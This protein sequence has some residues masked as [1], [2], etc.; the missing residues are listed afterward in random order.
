MRRLALMLIVVPLVSLV[1]F[2]ATQVLPG[3]PAVAVAGPD[4]P[5]AVVARVRHDMGFDQPIPVQYVRWLSRAVRGD[6]GRS[7]RQV[8]LPVTTLLR[9]R[10]P[11]SL[12]LCALAL[13]LS[14][15]IA[16]PAGLGAALRRNSL[17]DLLC[18][19][20]AMLGASVPSFV[21]GYLLIYIFGAKLRWLPPS[22]YVEFSHDPVGNLRSIIL[23]ATTLALGLAAVEMRLIRGAVLDVLTEDFIRTARAK[24]LRPQRIIFGHVMRNVLIP[25]TTVV[26]VQVGVLLG[27]TVIVETL[28]SIPGVGKMAVDSIFARDMPTIQGVVLFMAVAFLL[29]NLLVDLSYSVLDPRVSRA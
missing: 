20:V 5:P 17:L 3:D 21:I 16:I 23:P 6:L 13:L 8:G 7:T 26:G 2:A 28:F 15:L 9:Q 1:A 25:F 11:T 10:V 19:A 27:S 18:S 14:V 22:G 24:G 4:A 29:V 12:E